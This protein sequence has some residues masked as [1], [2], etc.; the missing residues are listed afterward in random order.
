MPSKRTRGGRATKKANYVE[1]NLSDEEELE[2]E[3]D[4]E[5]DE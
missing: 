4:E 3:K 5:E 2:K 1:E